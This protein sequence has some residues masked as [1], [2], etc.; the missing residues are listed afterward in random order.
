MECVGLDEFRGAR[1]RGKTDLDR[2][3]NKGVGSSKKG[4]GGLLSKK[5]HDRVAKVEAQGRKDLAMVAAK[6]RRQWVEEM[7]ARR[8]S[9]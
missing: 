9:R 1:K 4:W 8:E 3:K 5:K 2:A 6:L 7:G